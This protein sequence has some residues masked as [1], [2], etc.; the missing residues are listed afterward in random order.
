MRICRRSQR[1]VVLVL[2]TESLGGVSFQMSFGAVVALIAV[3]E[4]WGEQLRPS[5]CAAA[6]LARK[7]LG[8]CAGV[9][10]TTVVVTIERRPVLDLLLPP[11][12]GIRQPPANV[13]A[14]PIS[15]LW[16]LPW[17]VVSMPC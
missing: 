10:V 12:H 11:H 17:S 9:A 1:L 7:A 14:V 13:T 3:Y 2:E 5:C 16:T 4:T 15:A 8:L 6:S